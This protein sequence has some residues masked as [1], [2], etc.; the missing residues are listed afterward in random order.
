MDLTAFL[1]L[2]VCFVQFVFEAH[3]Q[4][5]LREFGDKFGK[6]HLGGERAQG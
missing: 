3:L 6:G 1:G 4:V 2:N 5:D